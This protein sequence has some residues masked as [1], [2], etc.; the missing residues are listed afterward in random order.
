[1]VS[2]NEDVMIPERRGEEVVDRVLDLDSNLR[3]AQVLADRRLDDDPLAD[4]QVIE[5]L[6]AEAEDSA[7][8]LRHRPCNPDTEPRLEVASYGVARCHR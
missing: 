1:M 5:T 8:P 3:A 4:E 2:G 7:C 6:P